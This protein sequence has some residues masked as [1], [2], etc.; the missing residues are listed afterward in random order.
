MPEKIDTSN[1]ALQVNLDSRF[2]G[3]FAEIG[4]GQEVA[5]WFLHVGGAAGTVAK[6]MSAYDMKFSDDIYGRG[7]RY[8]SRERILAMLD[9]EYDLL[10][11]RLDDERGDK[12][13]FFVFANSVSA[14]NFQGTNECH[15]WLGLRYQSEPHGEPSELLLHVNMRDPSNTRQQDALGILGVN[16][17]WTALL[18]PKGVDDFLET[19]VSDL[20]L[21]R[22]EIDVIEARGPEHGTNDAYVL[23]TKLVRAGLAQAVLL[24]KDGHLVQPADIIRKRPLVVERGMFMHTFPYH[25]EMLEDSLV[26]LE[27]EE[28]CELDPVLLPELS[29][30]PVAG[31]E[32]PDEAETL[33]RLE[34]LTGLGQ[35]ILLT[36]LPE[37][38]HLTEYLRR[39]TDA[40][41]RFVFGISTWV[42]ILN[43]AQYDDLMGGMLEAL[44]KLLADRVKLY[45]YAMPVEAFR[46]ALPV[47]FEL[48]AGVS[49]PT[50]GLVTAENIRFAEPVQHLYRYLGES[51]WLAGLA[52]KNT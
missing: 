6:T 25:R 18:G 10:I 1:R 9:H 24:S 43:H 45:I 41:M 33:R 20:S 46:G 21:N 15:G 5:R 52:P 17:I 30:N 12:T 39:Y 42:Q 2:Y 28:P 13:N 8:V 23:G 36:R 29:V 16:L 50:E 11:Q 31:M 34:E 48:T 22:I 19:L 26:R 49:V 51:G 27:K 35:P 38:Y 3:T 40:P 44:G 7:T 14:R 37:A 32:A 4:A 47:G